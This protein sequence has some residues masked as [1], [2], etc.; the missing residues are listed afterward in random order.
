MKTKYIITLFWIV[1][2]TMIISSC[3][4]DSDYIPS[5]EGNNID[6]QKASESFE[7]QFK[8]FWTA[9]NCN[10]PHWDYEAKYGLDWDAVYDKY[11]PAF[12]E[13]DKQGYLSSEEV[14]LNLKKL[15][16]EIL[17][18]L[19]DG[20]FFAEIRNL[21]DCTSSFVIC[22]QE[23]RV[24][25]RASY[26]SDKEMKHSSLLKFYLNNK[27]IIEYW[28]G[29]GIIDSQSGLFADNILYLW[30]Y[31]FDY[32]HSQMINNKDEAYKAWFNK[33]QE[34]YNSC[35]LKGIIIDLR[36][37]QGG[38]ESA[39]QYVLGALQ[40]YQINRNGERF[41]EVGMAR[42]KT[43]IGRYDYSPLFPCQIPAY[44]GD[45]AII[46]EQPIVLLVN[47]ITASL[48]EI[49]CLVAQQLDNTIVLG[50]QT[51]GAWSGMSKSY[52]ESNFGSVGIQGKTP[53]YAYIP[54]RT[55]I[56]S[57]GKFLEGEGI[58]PDIEVE[59]DVDL[60]QKEGRDNQLERALEYIRTGK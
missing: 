23:T 54:S 30:F 51:Y 36:N 60:F 26:L 15:Y 47:N 3:R 39:Y 8:A 49:T 20:H 56:T 9:M 42:I 27:Q 57:D 40:P 7:E 48:S 13:L 28:G 29:S 2:L 16:T 59:F 31:S 37:N 5:Y 35:T 25:K 43:G 4:E 24:E 17:S 34:L 14:E 21:R 19:H 52:S 55:F 41:C 10:Y 58:K 1:S 50:T 38:T 12:Q 33:I 46:T 22:P 32:L 44:S 53:F 6:F 18:P 45:H 11:L